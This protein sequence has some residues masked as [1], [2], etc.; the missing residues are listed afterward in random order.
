MRRAR[1]GASAPPARR[2]ARQAPA[3]A[4]GARAC[5][6]PPAHPPA[7]A[8]PA[9]RPHG[10]EAVARAP[11]PTA[12]AGTPMRPLDPPARP[13]A[14]TRTCARWSPVGGEARDVA[15]AAARC[16][17]KRARA[18]AHARACGAALCAARS[19]GSGLQGS[20]N[21]GPPCDVASHVTQPRRG[22]RARARWPSRHRPFAPRLLILT[23]LLAN[24]MLMMFLISLNT[25]MF[26]IVV[27][28]RF[29]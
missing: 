24:I 5:A 2:A 16:E 9:L 22:Q 26:D 29:N 11:S 21:L 3:R 15:A 27:V 10:R 8:P 23:V 17:G 6:R 28:C 20:K 4:A 1:R 19:E 14:A 12:P 18:R 25:I 7:R 13:P